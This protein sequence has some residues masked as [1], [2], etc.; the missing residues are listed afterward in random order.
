MKKLVS[1]RSSVLCITILIAA[2]ATAMAQN[3][4]FENTLSSL[5]YKVTWKITAA[6]ADWELRDFKMKEKQV[7]SVKS[8]KKVPREKNMYYR[9]G[10]QIE[11]Y[12]SEA[13]AE[14]RM[15]HIAATPPGPTSKLEAPEFDLREGFRRGKLVYV[16]STAVYMFVADGSMTKFRL[17]LEK[18]IPA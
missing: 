18:K 8:L 11:K 17:E 16:V 2:A 13:D 9:F 10:V 15:E 3:K 12:G 7:F 6:G 4:D 5:G 14:K 1:F